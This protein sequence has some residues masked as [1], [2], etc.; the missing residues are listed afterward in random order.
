[1]SYFPKLLFNMMLIFSLLP[2][3]CRMAHVLSMIFMF[4][5]SGAKHVLTIRGLWLWCLT[6]HSTIFQLHSGSL[7]YWWRKPEQPEKTTD[8]PLV[9]NKHYHIKL[10]RVHLAMGGIRNHKFSGDRYW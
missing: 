3:V 8:L 1:V 6:P 5:Y 7:F 10:Y 2:A 4:L 9:T